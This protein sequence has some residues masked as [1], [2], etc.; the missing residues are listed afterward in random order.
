MKESIQK[1]AR[2]RRL[3]RRAK[4]SER[5]II[6]LT[7]IYSV[8]KYDLCNDY[9]YILLAVEDVFASESIFIR[10]VRLTFKV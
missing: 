3:H 6:K 10:K 1:H 4:E 2:F 5:A 8:D 7:K 9:R